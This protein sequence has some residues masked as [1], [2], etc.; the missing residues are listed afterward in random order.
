MRYWQLSHTSEVSSETYLAA[1]SDQNGLSHGTRM[2][3]QK[4][5]VLSVIVIHKTVYITW[6]NY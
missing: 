6:Y 1:A 2:W 4:F 3:L 5:S